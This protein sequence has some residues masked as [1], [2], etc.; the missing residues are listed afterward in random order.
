[1]LTFPFLSSFD[2]HPG[3]RSRSLTANT[4]SKA[5]RSRLCWYLSKAAGSR[6]ILKGFVV[7]MTVHY[8]ICNLFSILTQK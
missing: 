4:L 1:L 7:Q 2:S 8:L 3:G 6:R 5:T